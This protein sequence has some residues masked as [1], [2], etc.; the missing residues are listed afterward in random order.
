MGCDERLR[1][2]EKTGPFTHIP[3]GKVSWSYCNNDG[4]ALR[5][6]PERAWKEH[7]TRRVNG[8]TISLTCIALENCS[9]AHTR[10]NNLR[11]GPKKF[12]L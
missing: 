2:A 4:N 8:F 10:H 11:A 3:C 6:V 5:L 7:G 1:K 12:W 9:N